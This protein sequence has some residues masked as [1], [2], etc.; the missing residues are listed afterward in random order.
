MSVRPDDARRLGGLYE[1]LRAPAVPAGGGAGA[2]AAWMARVEADGALAGLISR[3]LNGG[4]LLSTDVE[5][6]RA[7]TA[8]AGTSAAPAQVAAAY[9]LLLA[10]AA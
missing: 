8:S 4:D 3:L 7:L 1:T 10:H 9:E 5:A 6:A 2:M